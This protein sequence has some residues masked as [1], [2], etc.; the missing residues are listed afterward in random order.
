MFQNLLLVAAES[1]SLECVEFLIDEIVK[2]RRKCLEAPR[3][4]RE[5]FPCDG[6]ASFDIREFME[7]TDPKYKGQVKQEY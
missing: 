2:A 3:Q 7:H 4:D 1:E 6:T 5:C